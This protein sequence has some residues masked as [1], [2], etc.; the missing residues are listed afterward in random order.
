ME[1][2]VKLLEKRIMAEEQAAVARMTEKHAHE[3]IALIAEKVRRQLDYTKVD[4]ARYC[5]PFR[6]IEN[7]HS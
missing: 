3:M 6:C 4:C 1:E 7:K 5:L 2:R